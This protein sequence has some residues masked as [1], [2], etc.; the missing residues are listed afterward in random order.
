[1]EITGRHLLNA[2]V[3]G[4]VT[5]GV[6]FFFHAGLTSPMEIP[7]YFF[8]KFIFGFIAAMLIPQFDANEPPNF[9]ALWASVVF[10]LVLVDSYYGAVY[11]FG[12]PGLSVSPNAII[13]ILG[14]SNTLV[15]AIGWTIVHAIF[16][17]VGYAL[18]VGLGLWED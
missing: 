15:L 18:T 13:P 12:I 14:Y 1:M 8:S 11:F 17:L 10:S 4:F 2:V 9:G 16:F 6:D 7:T 3:I 5:M